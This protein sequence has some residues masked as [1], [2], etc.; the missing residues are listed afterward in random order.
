MTLKELL[1]RSS[2]RWFWPV[3]IL[4]VALAGIALR[5]TIIGNKGSVSYFTEPVE[6]GSIATIVNATGSVQPVVTVQVGSQVSGKIEALY[7]DY[8]SIV[9]RGQLLAKIDPRNFQAQ[10]ADAQAS[11]SA[12][13]AREQSA[14]ADL[15]TTNANLV[16]AKAN[17]EAARVTRDNDAL[18][19]HRYQEMSKS[20]II[21][22]NDYD[23]ARTTAE[24]SAAKY[25]QAAA[26]VE[27]AQAQIKAQQAQIKQATAQV[28]Q[29]QADLDDKRVN[30]EYTNIY[31]PVDGVVISRNVD[32]GQTVAA[33]L[34][35]PLLF[36]I[37]NDL[38]HMQVNASVD[39][40]DIGRI[41]P[42]V[43]VTFTVDAFPTRTFSGKIQE[44][45]LDPQTIQNVVTYSVIIGV[46]NRNLYLKPG[47]TAN[48]TITAD[49]KNDVLK[50]PNAALRYLPPGMTR[51]QEIELVHAQREITHSVTEAAGSVPS[52]SFP[53]A[54][55]HALE[56]N[57]QNPMQL[58]Q[59][60]GIERNIF[61]KPN[62][63]PATPPSSIESGSSPSEQAPGQMWNPSDKIQFPAVS[64]PPPKAGI[65]WI[66]DSKN[67]PTQKRVM[68][69]ITDGTYTELVSGDLRSGESLIVA[70]SSQESSSAIQT[71]GALRGPFGG[72]GGRR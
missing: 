27:Q 4:I 21:A 54:P 16:S 48:I 70:D 43:E 38:T 64:G 57:L 18:N 3:I 1:S 46:D 71:A 22:Q 32:V 47:M 19:Y 68:L 36:V 23:T 58:Q 29:A 12:A 39:E 65:V 52:R 62:A 11:L 25:N 5:H 14:K 59:S 30:L 60:A 56:K 35:A 72:F 10:V 49:K 6:R 41:A 55:Q 45:R 24:N 51:A 67:K 26:A 9:K 63:K 44:I 2:K 17:L 37:A 7:A 28:Q 34:Q 31:S 40:A 69:G 53:T 50:I 42:N 13:K 8:N 66:L 33:G 20:G 61:E 15:I